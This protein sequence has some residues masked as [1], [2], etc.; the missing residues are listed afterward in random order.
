MK[1]KK[2]LIYT[3][4]G[5]KKSVI[6]NTEFLKNICPLVSNRITVKDIKSTKFYSTFNEIGFTLLRSVLSVGDVEIAPYAVPDPVH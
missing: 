3:K 1:Q 2:S 5:L 4:T 6:T